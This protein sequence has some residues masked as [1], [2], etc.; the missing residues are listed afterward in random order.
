MCD[1]CVLDKLAM[2]IMLMS[3]IGKTAWGKPRRVG[4]RLQQPCSSRI[5]AHHEGEDVQAGMVEAAKRQHAI[6]ERE[7]DL[8]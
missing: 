1:A 2:V 3:L 4:L 7:G 5:Q 8:E 6:P